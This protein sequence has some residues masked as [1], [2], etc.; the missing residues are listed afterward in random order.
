VLELEICR[1]FDFCQRSDFKSES[2]NRAQSADNVIW[3]AEPGR[4]V[5]HRTPRATD[6]LPRT[7]KRVYELH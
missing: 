4:L 1:R 6:K 3:F 2:P 5:G 7:P